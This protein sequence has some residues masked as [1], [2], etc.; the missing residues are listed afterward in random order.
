MINNTIYFLENNAPIVLLIVSLTII[1]SLASKRIR[2][3]IST[4]MISGIIPLIV[5]ILNKL[6]LQLNYAYTIIEKLVG[7]SFNSISR[8]QLLLT[9]KREVLLYLTNFESEL[10]QVSFD[11][12]NDICTNIKISIA[13]LIY[14]VKSTKI[15][16]RSLLGGLKTEF[17]K[18][19]NLS[20]LSFV[21]R[22]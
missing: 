6:G 11:L 5:L 20:S 15:Q 3:I 9:E 21:Y 10:K 12:F 13:S 4:S 8:V 1:L 22:L 2:K 16:M 7:M 18:K 17:V 14:F 19:I